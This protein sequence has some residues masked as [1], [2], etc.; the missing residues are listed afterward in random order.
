MSSSI[1]IWVDE[2]TE[3]QINNNPY[4]L[5]GY[6]ITNSDKEEFDFLNRL[7]Q[8]RKELPP[9]WTT[10][11]GCEINEKDKRPL[12][13]LDRWI[14]AFIDSQTVYFHAFLYKRNE[15]FISKEK[16]YE[17]YFA[18]Q[19]VFALA[20]KMKKEGHI[21]N[22]IFNE[23]ST[24]NVLFDRRRSHSANIVSKSATSDISRINDLEEI[25]KNEISSQI[26]KISGK[27]LKTNDL[28]V[29]FSFIN[30]ECFDGM[31]FSDCLLYLIRKKIEQ[32]QNG[33]ENVF[34]ELFDIHFL[35]Y[36]DPHTKALG[37]RKIYEFSKKFNFFESKTR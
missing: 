33:Q 34:T 3:I 14:K 7:K 5:V 32:E 28:T 10:M 13:L 6:L 18:K 15:K 30:S 22:T 36:L 8:L 1:T 29:R 9:C 35:N 16:T 11:H 25:Y 31:Q 21:I 27:S 26:S 24:L 17:H 23:V 12:G 20:H 19:S 2:S 37:F 4:N